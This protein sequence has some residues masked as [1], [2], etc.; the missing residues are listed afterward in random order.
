MSIQKSFLRVLQSRRFRP[1][2]AP[3]ETS[4]DFRLLAATN[5]DIDARVS[6]WQFRQD[7][8]FRLRT[9]TVEL[10]PLR[11]RRG[12]V[13]R[14]ACHF[15]E[16][17][18]RK[19]KTQGK[20]FSPE[21]FDLLE[22]YEWPGN[23]RELLHAME[24]ALAASDGEG[25][26]YPRHLPV[27]IRARLARNMI[28]TVDSGAPALSVSIH[29]PPGRLPPLKDHRA[30]ALAQVESEYLNTL[31]ETTAW[32]IKEAC[33]ISGLSRQRL[34]ALLKQYGISRDK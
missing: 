4:S 15:L 5:R 25:I 6:T 28:E 23:V 3:V 27:D 16:Q 7:L 20:G 18:A 19:A 31:M 30:T 34:Y 2:G 33:D 8:L 17:H 12:D 26:L 22:Q 32:N 14:I 11:E 29:A 10:P 13:K 1:V 24:H 9:L 21:F